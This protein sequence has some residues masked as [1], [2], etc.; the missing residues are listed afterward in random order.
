MSIVPSRRALA[1]GLSIPFVIAIAALLAMA[2]VN[3]RASAAATQAQKEQDAP[4]RGPQLH[5]PFSRFV[6]DAIG[7]TPTIRLP[8]VVIRPIQPHPPVAAQATTRGI[9]KA[10]AAGDAAAPSEVSETAAR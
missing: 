5:D 2:L 3:A 7:A 10:A 9:A 8:T 4:V 6:Y 1:R